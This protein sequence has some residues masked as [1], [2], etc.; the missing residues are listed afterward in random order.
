[1][2]DRNSRLIY[3][4]TDINSMVRTTMSIEREIDDA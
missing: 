1:M 3:V 4:A 2:L